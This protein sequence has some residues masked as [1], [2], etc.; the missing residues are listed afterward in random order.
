M[1]AGFNAAAVR[2]MFVSTCPP[3][4][5]LPQCTQ[6]THTQAGCICLCTILDA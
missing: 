3:K 1:I 2:L 6:N 4:Y 5:V